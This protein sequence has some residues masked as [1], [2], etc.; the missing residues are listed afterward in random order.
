MGLD[1]YLTVNSKRVKK[2]AWK[3]MDEFNRE[4]HKNDGVAIYWRKANHI[5]KWFVDNVQYGEDDCHLYE[6]EVSKLMELSE[7]CG[8]VLEASELE[9]GK[10]YCGTRIS[11]G[12][13]EDI[14]EDGKVIVDA[15]TASELL[16]TTNGFFF[17]GTGYDQWYLD[18]VR[19]TKEAIDA[20]LKDLVQDEKYPWVWFHKDEPD[21]HVEF[22]YRSSW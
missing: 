1:M 9:N 13:A 10:V 4:F 17:G 6:V 21:W 3:F 16:P 19:I 14:Y 8:K 12:K 7:T 15:T 18:D 22:T 5:H 2:Q 20:M 11:N